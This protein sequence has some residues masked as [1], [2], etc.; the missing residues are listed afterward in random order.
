[1][2]HVARRAKIVAQIIGQIIGLYTKENSEAR[3]SDCPSARNF[4]SWEDFKGVP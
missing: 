1:M 4:L 2:R 3:L